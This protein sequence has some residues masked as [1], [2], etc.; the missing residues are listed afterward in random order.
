MASIDG[1]GKGD[2]DHRA[3]GESKSIAEI[4][5]LGGEARDRALSKA[6]KV[7]IAHLGGLAKA[8]KGANLPRET[9]GGVLWEGTPIALPCANLTNGMRVLSASG[10]SKAFGSGKKSPRS[11]AE[12]G[13]PHPPAFLAAKNLQDSISED[14][15]AKLTSPLLYVPRQGGRAYGYE[16]TILPGICRV[17]LNARRRELLRGGQERFADAAEVFLGALADFGIQALVDEATGFRADSARD[18]LARI[19]EKF[20]AK[21]LRPWVKTFQ[22]DFYENMFRLRGWDWKGMSVN[23]P[24]AAAGYTKDLIYARLAPGVLEELKRIQAER[25]LAEKPKAAM[26]RSLT[27]DVGHPKLKEHLVGV[28]AL[29]KASTTWDGFMDM[30]DRV[31][32]KYG[33]TLKLLPPDPPAPRRL[34]PASFDPNGT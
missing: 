10:V 3:E 6:R 5:S 27:D 9:H 30:V 22:P 31:Y 11:A 23:R 28:T 2:D 17:L 21:E 34:P 14:L 29:M 25:K 8:A 32:P 24:Q 19:L 16:A 33:E 15:R 20:I 7:E 18:A 12:S 13:A 4:A 1:G 26:F